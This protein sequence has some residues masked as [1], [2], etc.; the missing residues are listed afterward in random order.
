[1]A[2]HRAAG[3]RHARR[4]RHRGRIPRD[5]RDGEPRNR[6]HLRGYARH[7]RAHTRTRADRH[8]GIL[9]A[10]EPC[11][12]D[13][14]QGA[15]AD[16]ADMLA[17]SRQRCASGCAGEAA[18]ASF[19]ISPCRTVSS[20]MN[21]SNLAGVLSAGTVMP[22][23]PTRVLKAS[24]CTTA[25]SCLLRYSMIGFGVLAGAARPTKPRKSTL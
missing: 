19:A 25:L 1:G 16:L 9:L 23:A 20:R 6:Q 7:P 24:D 21:A 15:D 11:C 4:Q 18:F 22:N 12:R 5:A 8:P 13:R 14:T 2:R 10:P 3:A 17:G